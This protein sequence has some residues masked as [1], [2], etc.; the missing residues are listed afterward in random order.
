M[1]RQSRSVKDA[2]ASYPALSH[3]AEV[4]IDL[5][6]EILGSRRTAL[7]IL[8]HLSPAGEEMT[9]ANL[10]DRLRRAIREPNPG[11]AE[12][13]RIQLRAAL[14]FGDRMSHPL[15]LVGE[16]LNDPHNA[17]A[18]FQKVIG[19]E[20]VEM[21]AVVVVDIHHRYLAHRVISSG[22]ASETTAHPREI[23]E[24]V[25]RA[26]GARFFVGHSHPSGDTTPS[27]QDIKLT[28]ELLDASKVMDLP[29]L[30]HIVV[31]KGNHCSLRSITQLWNGA[32]F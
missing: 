16:V 6:A 29:L 9:G 15:P 27:E 7:G 21:L 4:L 22:S 25:I 8:R 19:W 26:G 1:P 24:S 3:E 14:E 23:F 12:N 17:A 11:L 20:P 2:G 30:D 31:G 10:R 13:R 28:K 5:I 32:P 18:I